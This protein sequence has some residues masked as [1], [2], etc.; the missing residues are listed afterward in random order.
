[1]PCRYYDKRCVERR[2]KLNEEAL[3]IAKNATDLMQV[4][5]FTA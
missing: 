5:D 1:M 3:C 4:V 2:T